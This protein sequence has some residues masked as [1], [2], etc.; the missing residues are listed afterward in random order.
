MAMTNGNMA[1]AVEKNPILDKLTPEQIKA[2][3]AKIQGNMLDKNQPAKNEEAE[4]L[5]STQAEFKD[6]VAAE[7]KAVLTSME[8]AIHEQ[9]LVGKSIRDLTEDDAYN[10][11]IPIAASANYSPNFLKIELKDKNYVARWGNTNSIRQGQLIAQGFKYVDKD[12]VANIDTLEMHLDDRDHFI[13]ADL[14]AVKIPK[15]IY[16]AGLRRAYVKSLHATNNKKAAE[17][18]AAF[19]KTQHTGSLSGAERS[20]MAQHDAQNKPI[21]NPTIGV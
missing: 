14:I 13:W 18:G 21:Y 2:A 1:P 20:Y 10:F 5:A 19:A 7:T 6:E 3:A 11:D 4:L 16:Y 9:S 12:D 8:Q 17:A 15:Q